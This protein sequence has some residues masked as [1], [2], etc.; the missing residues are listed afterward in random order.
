MRINTDRI[1]SLSAMVVGVGSLILVL[2][3]TQLMRQTQ[4]ASVLPYLMIAV[5][6]ND[7]GIHL[8]LSNTGVGPAL[9]QDVRIRHRGREIQGDPYDF[10]TSLHPD[11]GQL[12]V[13]KVIPGQ[14]LPAG[15]SVQMLGAPPQSQLRPTLLRDLLHVFEIAEVP[16]RW[17]VSAG[18]LEADKAVIE[19]TYA[20][21]YGD[22]WRIRSDRMVPEPL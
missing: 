19:I 22:R 4:K 12:D 14:L 7:A 11:S 15:S 10:F 1:V 13:V 8:V 20:S 9:I 3:Q 21:V 5:H 17:Y 6:A 2:Y 18:A 16:R